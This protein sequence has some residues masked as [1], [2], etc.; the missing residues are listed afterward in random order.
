MILLTTAI[1]TA[2]LGALIGLLMNVGLIPSSFTQI[3]VEATLPLLIILG[4]ISFFI[5]VGVC[6]IYSWL[7]FK[8][9]TKSY[10][11][12]AEKY[13]PISQQ[14]ENVNKINK[15]INKMPPTDQ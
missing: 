5:T 2:K 9:Y 10:Q 11:E 14:D 3:G 8:K 1:M 7:L 13:K 12:K 15:N 6:R 4:I